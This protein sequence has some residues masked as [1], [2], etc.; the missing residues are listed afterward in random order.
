[1][2]LKARQ[3]GFFICV[4]LCHASSITSVQCAIFFSGNRDGGPGVPYALPVAAVG[5][6]HLP[7]CRSGL[8]FEQPWFISCSRRISSCSAECAKLTACG[9]LRDRQRLLCSRRQGN[10]RENEGARFSLRAEECLAASSA[11]SASVALP[12]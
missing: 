9:V 6:L 4:K 11:T 5:V 8:R 10:R 3:D 7:E 12:L 1:M 2:C